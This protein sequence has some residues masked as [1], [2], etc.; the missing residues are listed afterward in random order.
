MPSAQ[1]VTSPFA[2]LDLL[3]SAVIL[4]DGTLLVRYLNA[5]AENLFATSRRKAL[6]TIGAIRGRISRC[7]GPTPTPSTSIA[8]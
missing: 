1:V 7:Y 6:A 3:S 2:G 5:G 4:V 8:P